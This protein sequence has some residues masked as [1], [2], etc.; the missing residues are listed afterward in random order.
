LG[1]RVISGSYAPAG[2]WIQADIASSS[3]CATPV[4]RNAGQECLPLL[5]DFDASLFCDLLPRRDIAG[6]TAAAA[7]LST[8]ERIL[9]EALN[10]FA[11]HGYGGASMRELARGGMWCRPFCSR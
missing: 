9:T 7:A 2:P 8:R 3:A 4:S 1:W 10:L 6:G 5:P 11:Q